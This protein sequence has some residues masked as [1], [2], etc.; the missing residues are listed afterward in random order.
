MMSELPDAARLADYSLH[1]DLSVLKAFDKECLRQG[2]RRNVIM[3]ADL[4]DLREGFWDRGEFL[5]ACLQTENEMDSL[6]LAGIGTNLG[7]YGSI[8][9][10][11]EKM[12]ELVNLARSVESAI[13]RK[14]EIVSGGATSSY[15]LLHTG[16][17]PDV[18]KRQAGYRTVL[19]R[20]VRISAR[21]Q[22]HCQR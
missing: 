8:R 4:G 6:I 20:L 1:S 22:R 19:L 15:L 17:M 16:G 7:C 18:Y 3:M 11:T 5:R 10:T 9:P 14:L 13:G 2:V 21:A 12:Q